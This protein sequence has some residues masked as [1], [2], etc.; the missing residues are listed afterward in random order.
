M[1]ITY[2]VKIQIFSAPITK[3]NCVHQCAPKRDYWVSC[4]PICAPIAA[5]V[6]GTCAVHIA[7]IPYWVTDEEIHL[8]QAGLVAGAYYD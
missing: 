6:H 4:A 5:F 1:K 8:G 3:R 7:F 2:V